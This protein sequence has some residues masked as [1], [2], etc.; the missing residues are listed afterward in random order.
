MPTSNYND[1]AAGREKA[2]AATEMLRAGFRPNLLHIRDRF[3]GNDAANVAM[4]EFC[5]VMGDAL[6]ALEDGL[7]AALEYRAG[8]GQ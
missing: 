7:A 4:T 2:A 3:A 6:N 5:T 8:A 1:T